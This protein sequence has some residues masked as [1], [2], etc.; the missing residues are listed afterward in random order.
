MRFGMRK[1]GSVHTNYQRKKSLIN[2]YSR[3][4]SGHSNKQVSKLSWKLAFQYKHSQ[5]KT[6]I[7]QNHGMT[8]LFINKEPIFL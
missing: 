8:N 7:R 2:F 3:N 5:N 4:L 6:Y 1:N